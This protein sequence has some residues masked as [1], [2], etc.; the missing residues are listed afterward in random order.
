ML[1]PSVKY[2][3]YLL[4]EIIET[5]DCVIDATIGNGFDT[6][7]SAEL[8]GQTGRVIGFDVQPLAI[9]STTEQLA[10]KQL[11]DRVSLHLLGHENVDTALTDDK[12]IKAAIFNLGY[13]PKGDK[14]IITQSQT[15]L[16]AIAKI[17]AR[18]TP[19]GRIVIV[20]YYGHPGGLDE[21]ESVLN[22]VKT[23][24]QTNFN[25]LSY[26]FINQK[27]NPPILICIEK[28]TKINAP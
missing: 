5:G 16:T 7:F 10:E 14:N 6:V 18:L 15:T 17:M 23:I 12:L 1:V 26:E 28:K 19:A 20:I 11:L 25:V 13:L 4:K 24:P 22:F 2:S 3:H 27:N 8:V 9:T 21:K